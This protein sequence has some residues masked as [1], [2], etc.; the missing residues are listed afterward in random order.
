MD[1]NYLYFL[2]AFGV[3]L[4]ALIIALCLSCRK[5]RKLKQSLRQASRDEPKQRVAVADPVMINDFPRASVI[6]G[7][8]VGVPANA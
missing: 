8:V 3:L 1:Q 6:E 2:P 5:N 4:L 7:Q